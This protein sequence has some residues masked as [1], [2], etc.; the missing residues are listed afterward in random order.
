[1]NPSLPITVMAERAREA[2]PVTPDT[3]LTRHPHRV[4]FH[5]PLRRSTFGH[6]T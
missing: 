1:V 6:Y 4:A 3:D 5:D 2:I